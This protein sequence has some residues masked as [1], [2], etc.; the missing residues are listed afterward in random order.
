VKGRWAEGIEPRNFAWILKDQLAVS[1]RPGG[2]A[3]HHRKVRRQEEI[4]WLHAH[5]FTRVVSLLPSNHNLH[6]YDE[7]HIPSAH[8]AVPPH[9]DARAVLGELYEALWRWLRDGERVLVHQDELGEQVA[10][11]VAGFLCW[12][13]LLP[14]PPRAVSVVEQLLRRQMGAAGRAIVAATAEMPPG[15]LARARAQPVEHAQAPPRPS[16]AQGEAPSPPASAEA[17]AR[18]DDD[19][20]GQDEERVV[21]ATKR[22]ASLVPARDEAKADPSPTSRAPAREPAQATPK[23][24][25]KATASQPAGAPVAKAPSRTQAKTPAQPKPSRAGPRTPPAK[26]SA[27]SRAPARDPAQVTPKSASKAGPS[28]AALGASLG[29]G[30]Q[31]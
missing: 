5:G 19:V 3:P 30:G 16:P 28:G 9:G 15:P 12:V 20:A 11:V 22:T 10:G 18:I 27:A 24:P 21:A 2:F 7:L 1:E 17:S 14:E 8:F 13:G 29:H 26:A 25:S 23:A 31:R 4:L 6:A